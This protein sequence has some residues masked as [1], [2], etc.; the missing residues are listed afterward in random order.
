MKRLASRIA[1]ALIRQQYGLLAI[2]ALVVI[3]SFLLPNQLDFDRKVT[4]MIS[5]KTGVLA[6]FLRLKRSFGGNEIVLAVYE[7]PNLLDESG[8]G[9]AR[10]ETVRTALEAI[11]GVRS[12]LSLDKLDT[13]L[14]PIHSMSN[15]I[16][17]RMRKLFE[18]YTP[19]SYTHLTLPTT[20]YV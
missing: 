2:A 5:D 3:T 9:I 15:P 14:T 20:P 4:N 19:V 12:A 6:P 17:V 11:E 16:S 18:G 8:D 10:L 7:D 13:M 1:R